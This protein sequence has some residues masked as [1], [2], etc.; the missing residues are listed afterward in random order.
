M[1]NKDG[2]LFMGKAKND[3]NIKYGATTV[4]SY[5]IDKFITCHKEDSNIAT[6]RPEQPRIQPL[7]KNICTHF[8]IIYI[9]IHIY[10]V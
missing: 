9:Y 8:I 2:K 5:F 6:I 7:N 4:N 10:I 1:R 3:I